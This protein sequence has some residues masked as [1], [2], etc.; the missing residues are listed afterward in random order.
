[1][2]ARQTVSILLL[3]VV[4]SVFLPPV[5]QTTHN[6][7][8]A[9][10]ET[11][12]PFW[13]SAQFIAGNFLGG[14]DRIRRFFYL[15]RDYERLQEEIENLRRE[16]LT[17]RE[18][19][20][21]NERLSELLKLKEKQPRSSRVGHIISRSISHWFRWVIID[22]G[23]KDGVRDRMV[24][25][26][27]SGVVGR[28]VEVGSSVSQCILLSD[29]ESRVSA[30]TQSSRAVGVVS[31]E[32]SDERLRMSLIPL[33]ASIQIGDSVITSGLSDIYPKGLSIGKVTTVGTDKDGMHLFAYVKP[34]V[35]FNRLEEVL[36]I[37]SYRPD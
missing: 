17:L 1:V 14:A 28:V 31:G 37:D 2:K 5:Q 30:M 8:L 3:L 11:M 21:E 34:E 12:E 27:N 36:C 9:F 23:E 24:L 4:P 20:K 26:N 25:I 19:E 7:R 35:D 32:G 13:A 18:I 22:L 10:H 15:Y 29:P 16:N 6:L 33:E